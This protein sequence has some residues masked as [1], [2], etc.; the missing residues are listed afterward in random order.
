MNNLFLPELLLGVLLSLIFGLFF[1][2]PIICA[3]WLFV[4][5]KPTPKG[6]ILISSIALFFWGLVLPKLFPA[7]FGSIGA[8]LYGF[9]HGIMV[10]LVIMYW[11]IFLNRRQRL[12]TTKL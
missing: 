2:S 5:N 7:I 6:L 10:L 11:R 9:Y 3:I 12:K 8:T 1:L 4:A